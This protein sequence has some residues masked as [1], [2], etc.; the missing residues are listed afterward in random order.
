MNLHDENRVLVSSAALDADTP[1]TKANYFVFA[2]LVFNF[3][4]DRERGKHN[5]V[6][7]GNC[8]ALPL[9]FQ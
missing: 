7:A 1:C 3:L 4:S 2:V 5:N 9:V 6:S 8:G